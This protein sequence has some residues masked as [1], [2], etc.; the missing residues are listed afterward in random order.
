MLN[1][2]KFAE[3]WTKLLWT[4]ARGRFCLMHSHENYEIENHKLLWLRAVCL[5]V[6]M[7]Y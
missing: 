1:D 4:S 2:R 7:G 6:E 3:V 5:K